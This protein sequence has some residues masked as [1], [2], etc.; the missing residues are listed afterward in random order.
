MARDVGFSSSRSACLSSDSD[1]PDHPGR[2]FDP[3]DDNEKYFKLWRTK[4]FAETERAIEQAPPE[5]KRSLL[6]RAQERLERTRREKA[7][8]LHRR[9]NNLQAFRDAQDAVALFE[10][11]VQEFGYSLTDLSRTPR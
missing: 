5:R 1:L 8:P 10:P 11:A 6:T 3:R 2:I 4:Y 9:R 7:L